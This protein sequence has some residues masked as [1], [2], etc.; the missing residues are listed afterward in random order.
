MR[1]IPHALGFAAGMDYSLGGGRPGGDVA[2]DITTIGYRGII[3]G[4]LYRLISTEALT[5]RHKL[6]CYKCGASMRLFELTL[7]TARCW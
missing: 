3:V 4:S 7:V 6:E 2:P 5:F 1:E